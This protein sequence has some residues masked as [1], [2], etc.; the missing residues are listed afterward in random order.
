MRQEAVFVWLAPMVLVVACGRQAPD[1]CSALEGVRSQI[2]DVERENLDVSDWTKSRPAEQKHN[3]A[4]AVFSELVATCT[5]SHW[6]KDVVD[7]LVADLKAEESHARRP[8]CMND[9]STKL[10]ASAF[11]EAEDRALTKLFGPPPRSALEDAAR[12]AEDRVTQW[13][14][15]R[16]SRIEPRVTIPARY[17]GF[18]WFSRAA[19]PLFQFAPAAYPTAPH[20]CSL[21]STATTRRRPLTGS[22]V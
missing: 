14:K 4:E 12:E 18:A 3:A 2:H 20:A 11:G 7:C 16:A 6:S 21:R 17:P 13:E 5:A 9:P 1:P 22:P 10:A 8:D 19:G 15:R